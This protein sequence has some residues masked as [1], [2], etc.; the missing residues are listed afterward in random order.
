MDHY[1]RHAQAYADATR[2]VDMLPLHKCF[3]QMLPEGGRVLDAGC[4]SGRDTLAF[5]RAGYQIRQSV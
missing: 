3:L 4:G 1:R 5:R 2:N